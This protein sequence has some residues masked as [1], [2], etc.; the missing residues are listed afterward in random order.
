MSEKTLPPGKD[1][2]AAQTS[3]P[4]RRELE[5]RRLLER[6]PAGAYTCNPAGLITYFNQQAVL[7]W[8]RA[9]KLHDPAD[10]FCGSFKLYATDGTPIAHDQCWMAKALQNCA[11]YYGQEIVIERPD[12]SRRTA[13]VHANPIHDEDGAMLG[14]VNV[15]V[16]IS[17]RKRAEEAQAHLAAIV[18]S[19]DDAIIS[20][21]LGGRILSW[22]AGAER[23]FGYT[24]EEIVGQSI[25][26]IIP[27]DRRHEEVAILARLS[28]GERI[29]H[30]ETIR[31]T[32]AGQR[33][34]VSL[35]I[36]PIR[37]GAGR[38]VAASKVLRDITA[39]KQTEAALVSLKNQLAAQLIELQA[40]DRSKDEFLAVLAHELRNP[41]APIR[42]SLHILRL[43]GEL[44]PA[45]ER[46]H[47]VM[48]RQVSH[49][50]RLVDDLLEV[51]RI[52]QG[53]IEL[54]RESIEL[55]AVIRSAVEASRPAIDEAR[56]QLA[57]SIPAEPI[58]LDADGVRLAQV[59][60]NLLNNAARYTDPG[61]Q[62]WLTSRQEN[63]EAVIS[64]RD[65]GI[66][67]PA[68]KL[69]RVFDMFAQIQHVARRTA[70]GLGIGLTLVKRLT[71]MHGGRVEARS[72]GTGQGSEF[73]IW[74]PI[75]KTIPTAG[76]TVP[77]TNR[78]ATLAGHRIMVIDDNRDAADS[79]AM[80]LKFLGAEVRTSY[81]GQAALEL[82][83]AFQ[84]TVVLL[85]IGMPGL[86]GYEVAR[87]I[88]QQSLGGDLVLVA[89]TGWGQAEDR[90]RSAAAGFNH[91]FVKPVDP[92]ALEQL[93]ESLA[94]AA[95]T[96]SIAS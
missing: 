94:P 45:A 33:I 7:L 3:P 15:L 20:K 74:L 21:D 78:Q 2:E 49:L 73:L 81:D 85:D 40:A 12:G 76:K 28:R 95:A 50:V 35:S 60:S 53:K 29:D 69:A 27:P 79:L 41:L 8:G 62:I 43:S 48:E 14:A 31:L 23:L 32:K 67:I 10:R 52:S 83:P 64:V 63:D 66:G 16:D 68:D 55:A 84:P 22:N 58:L 91:H 87:R 75:A 77:A 5:L 44:T 71:E 54:R 47:E 38:I 59:V 19:S 82:L 1:D 37:D 30:Y 36:S 57:I 90:R 4:A 39:Q 46:V 34:D 6:L 24:P 70:G 89:M 26:T 25:L 86:D 17:D 51:S 88:R 96:P 9:P 93:L 56:H 92:A 72:R 18:A 80:L 13:L 61:G 11:E 65:T 42:N